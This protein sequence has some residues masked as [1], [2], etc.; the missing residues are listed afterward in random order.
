VRCFQRDEF[1]HFLAGGLDASAAA[2]LSAHVEDCTICEQALAE[3]AGSQTLAP[4][5]SPAGTTPVVDVEPS[6]EFLEYLRDCL[7]RTGRLSK[8]PG[9]RKSETPSAPPPEA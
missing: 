4:R 1:E 2:E 9:M 6:G 5:S 8:A 7:A 3:L